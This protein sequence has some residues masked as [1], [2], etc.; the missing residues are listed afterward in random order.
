LVLAASDVDAVTFGVR[1]L[2]NPN[3]NELFR[4]NAPQALR[5]R[6]GA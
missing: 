5:W 6:I 2:A 3:L 4:L 1:F